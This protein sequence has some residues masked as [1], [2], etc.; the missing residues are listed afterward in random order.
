[1][2]EKDQ[3]SESAISRAIRAERQSSSKADRSSLSDTFVK[4]PQWKKNALAKLE[5]AR[6]SDNDDSML[7]EASV[8][9]ALKSIYETLARH[10][11]ELK[12]TKRRLHEQ[13]ETLRRRKAE[14]ERLQQKVARLEAEIA[15][16]TTKHQAQIDAQR[17]ELLQFQEAYDQFEQQS[18]LVLNELD[19]Q[20]ECL[21]AETRRQYRWFIH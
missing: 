1:M 4:S 6:C 2:G 17:V 10:V 5:S 19:Q 3:S 20:N 14:N 15:S 16:L 8:Q 13:S 21:R 11:E 12:D 7:R 18:D 9:Q